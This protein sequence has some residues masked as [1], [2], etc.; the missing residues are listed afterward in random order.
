L[1]N[2]HD[3]LGVTVAFPDKSKVAVTWSRGAGEKVRV[4]PEDRA[5]SRALSISL[6]EA[7]ARIK[8]GDAPYKDLGGVQEILAAV[9]GKVGGKAEFLAA[10]AKELGVTGSLPRLDPGPAAEGTVATVQTSR[11]RHVLDC[12]F[13][14]GERAELTLN[15]G[16]IG[17]R[18]A[19]SVS[20]YE[21]ELSELA[22][23]A[24]MAE[25]LDAD[26]LA[27]AFRSSAETAG[28]VADWIDGARLVVFAPPA[29]K[30]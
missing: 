29:P 16:S 12:R 9:G 17:L 2:E 6:C 10:A 5:T 3:W 25:V 30:M 4:T 8:T 1:R 23:A 28:S 11:G 18:L 22:M 20:A 27:E 24:K 15:K 13:P 26:A 19:P 21:Q 14:T 7:T